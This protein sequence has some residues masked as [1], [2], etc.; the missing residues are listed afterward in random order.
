[1]LKILFID[2]EPASVATVIEELQEKIAGVNCEV[3]ESLANVEPVL[4]SFSPDIVILDIFRGPIQNN[5]TAG[6]D[7]YEM[8]WN[9]C[10]C[11]LVIYSANPDDVSEK[12]EEHP[13]VKRVKKGKDSEE[14]IIFHV[15]EFLPHVEALSKVQSDIRHHVN[16]ELQNVAPLVFK[17][18]KKTENRK[19]VFVRS[20]KRRIAAMMDEPSDSDEPMAC[21]EQY[22]Y[23]PVGSCILTGDIIWRKN[24][25]RGNPEHYFLVLTPSCD[26]IGTE[27]RK[28]KVDS[29]LVAGCTHIKNVLPEV[30]L[31]TDTN[32]SKADLKKKLVP[33][34]RKGYG[35]YCLPLPELPE[36]LPPMTAELKKLQLIDLELVGE[37]DGCEYLRVAS[38]DSPFREMI[39]WA[40]I[41]VTGRPGLPER[42]F[43]DWGDRIYETINQGDKGEA[44]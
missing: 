40:Y 8:I 42:D 9:K 32:K 13:F 22:L 11:P 33:F 31:S 27:K 16:R 20:A 38:V 4:E 23:P 41:Q 10:F 17:A 34:L 2:D 12:V 39:T 36:L 21:W 14:R 25:D 1:M 43:E 19:A 24:G 18:I 3:E 35:T 7:V 30:K 26:L 5:E 6:L 37:N 15:K 44:Q 29:V 28:P